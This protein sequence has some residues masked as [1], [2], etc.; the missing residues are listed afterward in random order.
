[1]SN[2]Q[3]LPQ[4]GQ[5]PETLWAELEAITTS[6]VDWRGGRL[7]GYV[8]W[9]GDDLLAVSRE[10]YR[11]F[12]QVNALSARV[13]PS[14]GRLEEAVLG[15]A[16]GL[17]HAP[18][19]HGVFTSGGTES[20]F[21]AVLAA[22]EEAKVRR[23][24]VTNPCIVVPATGHPSFNKA[25]HFLGLRVVR[26]PV[27]SELV[28]DPGAMR[29]AI[30]DDAILVVGSAPSYTHGVIDPIPELAAIA[31]D[32]EIP[33]HVDACV[34]GFFLPFLERLGTKV[35]AWD[36]RV[37]GVTSVSADLHKHGFTARG[38]SLLLHRAPGRDRF[39]S[40]EF[41]DWPNGRYFTRGFG[42]SRPGGALASAWAVMRTLGVDGY[43][44]IVSETMRITGAF[45]EGIAR[46]EGLEVV[47]KP[48]MNKF[49]YTARTLDITA[50]A[51][52]LEAAGW[53][54]GR[55]AAPPAINMH[56]LPVHAAVVERYLADLAS[57][58][59][60]VRTGRRLTLGKEAAYS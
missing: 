12:F 44:R 59:E 31:A 53:F 16:A 51:D 43:C 25:A 35:P 40:F 33:C 8:Y 19:P 50:V 48:I 57:S 23:P 60:E 55:Q 4:T 1:M 3:Q 21:L 24:G 58:V 32:R 20:N 2:D 29:Q 7:Q 37:P 5:S 46:I 54:V 30:G 14:V 56:V 28:A 45:Q 39:H 27:T 15:M 34:G 49:G 26:V 11:R 41:S 22:R 13:F 6:D 9:A 42:G 38:A 18:G 47:G 10:A 17:L 52:G 36:F